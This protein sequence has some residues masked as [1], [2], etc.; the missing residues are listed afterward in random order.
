MAD[1]EEKSVTTKEAMA[2]PKPDK[3]PEPKELPCQ[4][5][6][7][8]FQT[9]QALGGHQNAHKRERSEAKRQQKPN[10]YSAPALNPRPFVFNP[11]SFYLNSH[12]MS[13]GSAGVATRPN[14][15]PKRPRALEGAH[16]DEDVNFLTWQRK[17]GQMVA[18]DGEAP[19]EGPSSRKGSNNT[20]GVLEIEDDA[21][22]FPSGEPKLDLTLH[23]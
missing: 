4:F 8:K 15:P 22:G 1:Q 16:A 18:K 11:A 3:L 19:L 13:L 23:L 9:S 20:P 17:C 10:D 14:V 2:T 6:N 21:P 12:N 7:K 5:C